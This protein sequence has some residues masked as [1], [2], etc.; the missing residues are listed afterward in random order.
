MIKCLK[1]LLEQLEN[2]DDATMM[3]EMPSSLAGSLANSLANSVCALVANV[4]QHPIE[5]Y[6]HTLH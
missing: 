5:E 3:N 1:L 2:N 4:D 6:T